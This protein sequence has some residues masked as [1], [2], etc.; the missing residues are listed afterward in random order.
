[1]AVQIKENSESETLILPVLPTS[2]EKFIYNIYLCRIR[3]AIQKAF[4][5]NCKV[6]TYRDNR[7]EKH[8]I[9]WKNKK[10]YDVVLHSDGRRNVT[11]NYFLWTG[12]HSSL[13]QIELTL[14]PNGNIRIVQ[15]L[16]SGKEITVLEREQRTHFWLSLQRIFD[17]ISKKCSFFPYLEENLNPT[18]AS[19]LTA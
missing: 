11:I 6:E 17:S 9:Y 7:G 18:S 8:T 19:R 5:E 13:I 14:N 1:M 12:T 16:P 4:S 10:M 3:G 15:N 2:M